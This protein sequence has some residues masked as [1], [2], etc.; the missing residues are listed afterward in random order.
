MIWIFTEGLFFIA[1][2]IFTNEK[3]NED[4]GTFGEVTDTGVEHIDSGEDFDTGEEE[5]DSGEDTDTSQESDTCV[6]P[7]TMNT[8]EPNVLGLLTDDDGDGWT[9]SEGDCND[10]L[11][12]VHPDAIDLIIDGI[13]QDCDGLD[14]PD[15]DEDG[16]V[17]CNL[18]NDLDCDGVESSLDCDDT[19]AFL[20]EDA[21]DDGFCDGFCLG[22]Y[23]V[24]S[25]SDI[26]AIAHCI[27]IEGSLFIEG[28]D[29][30]EIETLP[31][32]RVGLMLK[33]DSNPQLIGIEGLSS[34]V[35]VDGLRI[36][37]NPLLD[38]I[39]GLRSLSNIGHGNNNPFGESGRF[40]ISGNDSLRHLDGLE[41]LS[42]IEAFDP[43]GTDFSIS[44]NNVLT[45]IDGLKN[46]RD[47]NAGFRISGNDSLTNIDGLCHV[48]NITGYMTIQG[49]NS[50]LNLD[51]LSGLA[52][53]RQD[54]YIKENPALCHLNGLQNATYIGEGI[55]LNQNI[56][57]IDIQGLYNINSV[58]GSVIMENNISLCQSQVQGFLDSLSNEFINL[59]NT[60]CNK[61]GC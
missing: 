46:L 18:T 1:C 30:T 20:W 33:I 55:N 16:A 21:D 52:F 17:D 9:E 11:P 48:N 28:A 49:N 59:V 15:F 40:S 13:D 19:R 7:E 3:D 10:M 5:D 57:L 58:D 8:C 24:A 45:N 41:G 6:L 27:E 42:T 32:K 54:I 31:L 25:V 47:I 60:C 50:L 61:D 56:S 14:G 2:S 51:G 34:L 12:S 22:S 53:I 44:G 38:N 4:T 37:S 29:F 43:F 35:S 26:Q 36:G 39:D 23:V